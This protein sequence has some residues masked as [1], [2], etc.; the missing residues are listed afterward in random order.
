MYRI[1]IIDPNDSSTVMSNFE[2]IADSPAISLGST[3]GTVHETFCVDN[4]TSSLC[5][6]GASLKPTE[7]SMT[8]SANPV[9]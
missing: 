5:P 1:E 4:P 2:V 8:K 3:A 6:D 9:V 7:L